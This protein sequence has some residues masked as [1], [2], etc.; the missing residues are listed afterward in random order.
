MTDLDRFVRRAW[1]TV[2]WGTAILVVGGIFDLLGW[3]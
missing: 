2:G 1:W 3:I